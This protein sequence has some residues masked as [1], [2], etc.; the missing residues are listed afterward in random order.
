MNTN[1][2]THTPSIMRKTVH[3]GALAV[4]AVALCVG[5]ASSQMAPGQPAPAVTPATPSAAPA[6]RVASQ[7]EVVF[8]RADADGDGFVSEA[9]LENKAHPSKLPA[10]LGNTVRLQHKFKDK[11]CCAAGAA[12]INVLLYSSTNTPFTAAPP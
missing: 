11:S 5:T 7:Y 10:R 4:A 6:T 8:K 9:E 3:R 2:L 12:L 1:D